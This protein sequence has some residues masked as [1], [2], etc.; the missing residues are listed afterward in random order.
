M[1]KLGQLNK[2]DIDLNFDKVFTQSPLPV[3]S[4]LHKLHFEIL[5][6]FPPHNQDATEG[7]HYYREICYAT[8]DAVKQYDVNLF[9]TIAKIV[10]E[11]A[12][13]V[14]NVLND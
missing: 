11:F 9:A 1:Q 14:A 8:F 13:P 7:F 3:D 5:D 6:K 2:Q 4:I 10:K 12:G